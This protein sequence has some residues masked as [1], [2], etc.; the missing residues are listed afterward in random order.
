MTTTTQSQTLWIQTI[1]SHFSWFTLT[2]R[3]SYYFMILCLATVMTLLNNSYHGN[4][5][6]LLAEAGRVSDSQTSS[7]CDSR[8]VKFALQNCEQDLADISSAILDLSNMSAVYKNEQ[9]CGSVELCHFLF[10]SFINYW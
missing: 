9:V 2:T 3:Y 6:A 1:T 5:W 10:W 8:Y 4:R 7:D